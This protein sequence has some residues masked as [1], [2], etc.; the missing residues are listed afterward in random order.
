M[1]SVGRRRVINWLYVAAEAR[2]LTPSSVADEWGIRHP[3]PRA[4]PAPAGMMPAGGSDCSHVPLCLGIELI[5]GSIDDY[6]PYTRHQTQHRRRTPRR[7]SSLAAARSSSSLTSKHATSMRRPRA[8]AAHAAAQGTAAGAAVAMPTRRKGSTAAGGGGRGRDSGLG[9]WVLTPLLL[10]V[11][12]LALQPAPAAAARVLGLPLGSESMY[13]YICVCL[14]P[15]C[16]R[17]TD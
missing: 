2:R 7:V 16:G 9:S 13:I 14:V 5:H 12:L 11:V 1:G 3:S 6:Q 4:S 10:L 8:A 15:W 17:P